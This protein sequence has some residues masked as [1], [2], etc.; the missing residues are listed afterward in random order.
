MFRQKLYPSVFIYFC[1]LM[2]TVEN[3]FLIVHKMVPHYKI[4]SA[5]NTW[6]TSAVSD[7]TKQ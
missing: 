7:V 3:I 6:H 5:C 2:R 4:I 1:N